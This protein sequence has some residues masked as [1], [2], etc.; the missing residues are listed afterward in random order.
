MPEIN[1]GVYNPSAVPEGDPGNKELQMPDTH[2]MLKVKSGEISLSQD[3]IAMV[4]A[5]ISQ[6]I[7][8]VRENGN[9]YIDILISNPGSPQLAPPK[10]ESDSTTEDITP[11]TWFNGSSLVALGDAFA[12]MYKA[13]QKQKRLDK[14]IELNLANISYQMSED[15]AKLR[16]DLGKIEQMEH[17]M[18]AITTA[19]VGSASAAISF[20]LPRANEPGMGGAGG[21]TL[22]ELAKGSFQALGEAVKAFFAMP[23]A[24]AEAAKIIKD[25]ANQ[26][27]LANKESAA[28]AAKEG[29]DELNRVLQQL[30]DI[31]QRYKE[32]M[33]M[34]Q[35]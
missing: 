21:I 28:Q 23:K 14:M 7:K 10:L 24:T 6:N 27:I 32:A 12:A 16:I 29:Q 3:S 5:S 11:N 17:I 31:I 20:K 34:V 19:L 1:T 4:D 8:F 26:L 25:A 30:S 13:L 9:L 35:G 15:S 22:M 2:R 33:K 18:G